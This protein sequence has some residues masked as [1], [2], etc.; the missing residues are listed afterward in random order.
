MMPR[1]RPK[2]VKN[3][4][5]FRQGCVNP[6]TV[7]GLFVEHAAFGDVSGE[8][9]SPRGLNPGYS[10]PEGAVYKKKMKPARF[11]PRNHSA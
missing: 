1:G 11:D 2:V 3:L 4:L 8:A 5:R 9:E 6:R 10:I 7:R